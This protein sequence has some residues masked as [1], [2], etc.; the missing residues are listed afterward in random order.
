MKVLIAFVLFTALS[1]FVDVILCQDSRL[2]GCKV[3]QPECPNADITF[4]LYTRD[5]QDDPVQLDLSDPSSVIRANYVVDRPLKVLIHGYTGHK[6]YAPNSYLRPAFFKNDEY[7]IV[8]VD[9]KG[10]A[11]SPCYYTAVRNLQTVANCTAQ[12]LN[13]FIDENI[14]SLDYIH[15]IGFSLGAQ[16]AG[17][18]ANYMPKGRKL[19]RITGLDPAKP[20]FINVGR[21]GRIDRSDADFV[22]VIHT[23]VFE[24]GLLVPLGDVDYYVNGG[25]NQPGCFDQSEQTRGSCNHD[26]A[27]I[28]YA[29]S[30]NS[31]EGFWGFKCSHWYLYVL[32]VCRKYED[33]TLSLMGEYANQTSRGLYFLN[34]YKDSP[35]AQGKDFLSDLSA[36][37]NLHDDNNQI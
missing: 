33:E 2:F 35:F 16:V 18:I 9:Y 14:F 15:V 23:D 24:R 4:F 26:R 12:L 37:S 6:D 32:G 36:Y 13:F 11:M 29:E 28:Y 10:L 8:S 22:D 20:L 5:T 21:Y 17:M 1:S 3:A 30:I 31:Q 19:R 34:T 27:P 7:N 25:F